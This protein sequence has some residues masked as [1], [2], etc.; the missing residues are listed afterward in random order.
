MRQRGEIV[1]FIV[2]QNKYRSGLY[3]PGIQD[4]DG[5]FLKGRHIVWR[6]GEYDVVWRGGALNK[7]EYIATDEGEIVGFQFF[8]HF[9]DESL[10]G[11]GFLY[12]CDLCAFA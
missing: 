3:K 5:N 6:I 8:R 10:L 12:G 2:L 1:L 7:A 4:F 9:F 11:L